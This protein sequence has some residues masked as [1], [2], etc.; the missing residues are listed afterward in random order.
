MHLGPLTDIHKQKKKADVKKEIE[1]SLSSLD[2]K[3]LKI[4]EGGGWV[5][6]QIDDLVRYAAKKLEEK[7][8][9]ESD[10]ANQAKE[11][12]GKRVKTNE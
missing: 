5:G 2:R 10:L 8:L 3:L 11:P 12:A 9:E 1:K 7:Q 4:G 6:D